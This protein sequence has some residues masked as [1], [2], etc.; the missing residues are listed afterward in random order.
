M[1]A[2]KFVRE[3]EYAYWRAIVHVE[4]QIAASIH[5][6]SKGRVISDYTKGLLEKMDRT[7]SQHKSFGGL[8]SK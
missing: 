3:L 7:I 4:V 1:E 2:S 5:K 6:V 8:F